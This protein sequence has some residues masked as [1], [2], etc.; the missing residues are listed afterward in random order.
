MAGILP[1]TIAML[2]IGISPQAG[3]DRGKSLRNPGFESSSTID[4]WSV[5]VYGAGAKVESDTATVHEGRQS[6]RVSASKSSDVALGQ[7]VT[8][9]PRRWYRFSGWVRTQGLDPGD[10]PVFGTFQVQRAGVP[11]TLA[12]GPSHRGD[13]DWTNVQL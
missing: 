7:D 12:G 11:G 3:L 10:A 5:V 1:L 4:G 8:L 9:Q 13:T 6:L 2:G